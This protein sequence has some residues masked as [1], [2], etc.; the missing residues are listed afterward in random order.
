MLFCFIVLC[1]KWW[2][3]RWSINLNKNYT[4]S[5]VMMGAHN[6]PVNHFHINMKNIFRQICM[7][8]HKCIVHDCRYCT[9]NDITQ[10]FCDV[11][12]VL[13]FVLLV[14]CPHEKSWMSCKY[15]C[16][17]SKQLW[18]KATHCTCTHFWSDLFNCGRVHSVF[19]RFVL[20][21]YFI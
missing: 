2:E 20:P 9:Y 13:P 15:I 4:L 3:E 14:A 21:I 12:K 5:Y 19:L 1:Q 10:R 8:T 11:M 18:Q 17:Y 6:R 16:C 7:C